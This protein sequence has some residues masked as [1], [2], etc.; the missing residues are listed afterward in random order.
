VATLLYKKLVYDI[1]GCAMEVHSEL[2]PG[3]LES[4]YEEALTLLFKEKDLQCEQQ[5]NLKIKFR[6]EY[7]KKQFTADLIVDDKV[8]VE[9]KAVAQLKK[10]DEAQLINYLKATGLKVGLLLNFGGEKLEWKRFVY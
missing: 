1:V 8:I 10:I 5:I 3:F 2:G 7:L 9:I 4:V 6:G